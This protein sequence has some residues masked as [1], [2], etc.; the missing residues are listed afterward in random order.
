[1][2]V[3]KMFFFIKLKKCFFNV[4]L[5]VFNIYGLMSGDVYMDYEQE[6]EM[7][8]QVSFGFRFELSK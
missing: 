1:M 7:S 8:M 6:E 2:H 4:F 5:F 3:F